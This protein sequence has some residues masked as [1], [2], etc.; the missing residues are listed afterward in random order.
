ME[1]VFS[2]HNVYL[3]QHTM[4]LCDLKVLHNHE[5]I[6]FQPLSLNLYPLSFQ[7]QT[8]QLQQKRCVPKF[9]VQQQAH[10][11][12]MLQLAGLYLV[13]DQQMLPHQ[14]PNSAQ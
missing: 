13:W 1:L 9:R 14:Q 4:R 11:H 5:G 6:L 3:L 7:T 12:P 8:P 2:H 10:Q